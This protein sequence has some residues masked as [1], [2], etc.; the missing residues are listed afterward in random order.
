MEIFGPK[1]NKVGQV[2][3]G[4]KPTNLIPK[5]EEVS[6]NGEMKNIYFDMQPI[7]IQIPKRGIGAAYQQ[8]AR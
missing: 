8:A 6:Y 3:P 1:G 7:P 4:E 5:K 2:I